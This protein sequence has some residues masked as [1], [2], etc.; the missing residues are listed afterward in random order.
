MARVNPSIEAR[1]KRNRPCGGFLLFREDFIVKIIPAGKLIPALQVSIKDDGES[2]L[3]FLNF[4]A[5]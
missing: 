3:F 5:K 1:Y 4:P 2:L